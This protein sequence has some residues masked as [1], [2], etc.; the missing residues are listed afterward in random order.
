LIA[1][2]CFFTGGRKAARAG[3]RTRWGVA[4]GRIIES[5][6]ETRSPVHGKSYDEPVVH[7]SFVVAGRQ[8]F[9]NVVEIDATPA[10]QSSA[11]KR[12]VARYRPGAAVNVRYNPDNYGE[13]EL[14]R[15]SSAAR[16][17]RTLGL[18]MSWIGAV[19]FLFFLVALMLWVGGII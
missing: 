6:V 14:V 15:A 11:A 8:Y 13:A 7:Y 18:F 17:R 5:R 1:L 4:H 12:I 16:W 9:G 10:R 3:A 2:W 19:W